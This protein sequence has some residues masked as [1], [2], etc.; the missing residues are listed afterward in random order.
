M[1]MFKKVKTFLL[2]FSEPEKVYCSG[3]K[4]AGRVLV[5]VA[6]VTRVSAVKV[7]ACGVAKVNWAKGPQ[8]CRQEMEYLRFEDVLT[9]E[10]QPTDEDGSVILRPG[11]KYEYK[12]GFEL[13]QGP[14]GTSFKGK[15]G[16]VDYWV[17]AFLERPSFPTQETKKRFEVMDPVDVNTP[18]LLSPV[19]AKKEKKVSCMFIPDGRVSVSAQIDRKGFCEGDEICINADFENTCSR[20]V[21]PKAAIIAKHTYLA[22]G[23]TKVFTQKLSC[24]RG[25]HIISGMSESWRGKTIRVKKLKPS[26]LGCNILRVE[27]F[28]QIYVSV[29]GSKKII[30]ELPLV[31]GSRSGIGSRSSS[32]ASQT[33]SEMSWVDL[34][35]PD[36]PEAP[37]CYLDIVPEDHRLESPTTP[38]LDDPDS[39]DSPI[40]MY[41]PEF[42]FMPPPTYT[43]VSPQGWPLGFGE[44]WGAEGFWGGGR[45][46]FWMPGSISTASWLLPQVDPCVANNNVQ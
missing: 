39:F 5:E 44:I 17:K 42:K 40:F 3:E 46:W 33:S 13:P 34:N 37:P 23:Q 19:A 10:E 20:I 45:A 24:V 38:L 12:F 8:Q 4:V 36:A 16:C 27:Y 18:E 1:V 31:I 28:L 7:L 11:N 9:L 29:P 35:L 25:N 22:N 32:M 30:L 26:I 41:A 14:L 2:A 6:E 43:E 15:Y 21:V